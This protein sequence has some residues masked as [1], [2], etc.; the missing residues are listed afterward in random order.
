MPYNQL[1]DP[2]SSSSPRGVVRGSG[3][4]NLLPRQKINCSKEEKIAIGNLKSE[5]NRIDIHEVIH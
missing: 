4:H 2:S 1:P 5:E 3:L